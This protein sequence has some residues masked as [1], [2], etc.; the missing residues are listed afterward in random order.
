ATQFDSAVIQNAATSTVGASTVSL[1]GLGANRNLVLIDGRRGQP[2]NASLAIDTNSIPTAAIQRM[3]VISGGASAVYGADAV[4]G[5]V[6]LILKD[7]FEGATL[8]ARYG[9]TMEGDNQEVMISG[10]LG[11]SFGD[12]RGNVMFGFEH[13]RRD[14]VQATARGWRVEDLNNPNVPG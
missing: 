10:L 12:D 2:V 5:V 11:A 13:S 14:E 9:G 1:R 4:G 8:D 7:D 3:E 6:N